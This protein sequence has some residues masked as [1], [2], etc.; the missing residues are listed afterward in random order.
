MVSSHLLCTICAI[1]SCAQATKQRLRLS[2]EGWLSSTS[3]RCETLK[4][5]SVGLLHGSFVLLISDRVIHAAEE[6][7][8]DLNQSLCLTLRL[9]KEEKKGEKKK[10]AETSSEEMSPR[11]QLEG[12]VAKT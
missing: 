12:R 6:I 7:H 8:P 11:Y 3:G 1:N 9:K 10:K 2:Q 5:K 4:V